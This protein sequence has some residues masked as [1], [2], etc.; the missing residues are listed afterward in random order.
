[1]YDLHELLNLRYRVSWPLHLVSGALSSI[2][3]AVRGKIIFL[4]H[5]RKHTRD[6]LAYK[7]YHA[8]IA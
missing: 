1:M 7:R 4:P 2:N 3:L 5:N 6:S 8:V